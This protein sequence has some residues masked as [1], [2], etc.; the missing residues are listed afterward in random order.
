MGGRGERLIGGNT[1][2]FMRG[3]PVTGPIG[4]CASWPR[5]LKV[6]ASLSDIFE[7][8]LSRSSL[9]K[10]QVRRKMWVFPLQERTGANL[11]LKIQ[12]LSKGEHIRL[13][14]TVA[15]NPNGPHPRHIIIQSIRS[16]SRNDKQHMHI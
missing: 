1:E 7:N 14:E 6:S 11:V 2:R 12:S 16:H 5:R 4:R 9:Q 8:D 3:G 10:R 15:W 13:A